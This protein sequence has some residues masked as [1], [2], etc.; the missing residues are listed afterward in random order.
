MEPT[1]GVFEV[2]PR[3]CPGYVFRSSILLGG[4]DMSRSEICSFME[5]IA[6]QYQGN[7]YNL[8]YKNCN[9]F[10][11]EVSHC[12]TGHRIPGWVNRLARI[13]NGNL[14]YVIYVWMMH[15]PEKLLLCK[16]LILAFFKHVPNKVIVCKHRLFAFF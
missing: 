5:L 13:G 11:D 2:E 3:H 8:I 12:L 16:H 10:T 4:T 6:D 15:V 7:T 9:H 1:S 14:F